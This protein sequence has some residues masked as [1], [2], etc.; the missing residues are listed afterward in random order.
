MAVRRLKPYIYSKTTQIVLDATMFTLAWAA[1]YLIRFEGIPPWTWTKQCLLWL[2]YLVASRAYI[3]WRMGV[4]RFIW[5]YVSLPDAVTIARSLFF[6]SMLLLAL[7]FSYPSSMIF[8]HEIH[9]PL[10]VIASEYL[11]SLTGTLGLR[12]FRRISYQQSKRSAAGPADIV[13]R[14]ILFGAGDA[15]MLLASD[16]SK[17]PDVK[18][19]GFL[20]DDP[21]KQGSVISEL[22]VLG[23]SRSLEQIVR[24]HGIDQ[25]VISIAT[26]E[27]SLL[28]RIV[29]Q[30]RAIPVLVKIIPSLQEMYL[31][32]ASIS[33][34]RDVQVEDLLGR[35]S[36]QVADRPES[37]RQMYA[38]TRVLVTG[39]GGSIG[40]EIVH[41]LLQFRP[42]SIVILDKDEN[43]I[44]ELQQELLLLGSAVPIEPRIADIRYRS[45]LEAIF[46]ESRPSIV[47]HAAAHKHVPMMEINP[48]EAILNNVEGTRTL[49]RVCQEYRLKRFIYISSD[50]A[51]NPTNV[52]GATKRIG[53]LLVHNF[54]LSGRVPAACVRFGNVLGSRGSVIPLFQ[55]QIA[56]GRPVTVTHPDIVRYFMTIPEAVH[57]VLCAGSLASQGE[58]FV[59]DMGNPRKIMDLAAELITLSGLRP[60]KDIEIRITG[61]RP[62]EKMYEELVEP[63]E[64]LSPTLIEKLSVIV[65][66]NGNHFPSQALRALTRAALENDL[67]AVYENIPKLVPTFHPVT[68]FG[69]SCIGI[70]RENG[71]AKGASR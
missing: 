71:L 68:D 50:K 52:M 35:D 11:L 13:K 19:V 6:G 65:D 28:N 58:T 16:L 15:G 64:V 33:R 38:G 54:A 56:H 27:K 67:I 46:F 44:Y 70:A 69:R 12:A 57:L 22:K 29:S 55:Q 34:I 39:A 24:Q 37:V 63:S 41:Q 3:S 49:L 66:G 25:V 7:R 61:L 23:D 48:C 21:C 26:P 42:A 32:D 20:D 47:F 18:L 8:A 5:K 9:V 45:R 4:Y 43:S 59:L 2:P 30:C 62:G 31:R 53:E 40:R 14:V 60:G 36:V 10:G 17:R 51:V 1:A